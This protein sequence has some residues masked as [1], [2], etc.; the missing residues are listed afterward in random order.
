MYEVKSTLKTSFTCTEK[1]LSFI[2]IIL[3]YEL[4]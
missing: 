4:Y 2:I 3:E 1:T